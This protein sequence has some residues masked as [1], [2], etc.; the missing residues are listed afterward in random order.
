[1]LGYHLAADISG[2]TWGMAWP[3]IEVRVITR[4]PLSAVGFQRETEVERGDQEG[5]GTLEMGISI[6]EIARGAQGKGE[7]EV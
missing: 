4:A 6:R 1:M 2:E 5:H 7:T 3:L